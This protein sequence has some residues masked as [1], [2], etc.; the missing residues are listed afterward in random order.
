MANRIVFFNVLALGLVILFSIISVYSKNA[1]YLFYIFPYVIAIWLCANVVY[2]AFNFFRKRDSFV[3]PGSV[4]MFLFLIVSFTFLHC[5]STYTAHHI[6]F[7]ELI[8]K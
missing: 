3:S 2:L 8:L 1:I 4:L 7:G 5:F 6:V